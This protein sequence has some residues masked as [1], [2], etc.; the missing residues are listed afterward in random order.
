MLAMDTLPAEIRAFIH[1]HNVAKPDILWFARAQ[2]AGA[3]AGYLLAIYKRR[4]GIS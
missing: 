2:A 1:E 3:S 4:R